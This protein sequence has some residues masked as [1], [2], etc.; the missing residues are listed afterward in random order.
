MVL[1]ASS[2]PDH[3]QMVSFVV[4]RHLGPFANGL[5]RCLSP[6]WRLCNSGDFA[7]L[8]TLQLWRLCSFGDFAALETLQL[9][10]RHGMRHD[11]RHDTRHNVWHDMRHDVWHDSGVIWTRAEF[12]C[13][14]NLDSG[15][16]W[17]WAEFR[18]RQNLDSIWI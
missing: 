12:A 18:I 14:R 2:V 9:W 6:L 10:S 8:E 3:L 16:I 1:V 15:G 7:T 4:S 11:V 5:F 13:R 17:T